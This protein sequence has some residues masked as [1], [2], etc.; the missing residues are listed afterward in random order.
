MQ[1]FE[2]GDRFDFVHGPPHWG[3][4]ALKLHDRAIVFLRSLSGR[5]YESAWR[6]HLL[7]EDIDGVPYA[8]YQHKELWLSPTLPQSLRC[9]A[10]QDPKRGQSSAIRLTEL[11]A[12]LRKLIDAEPQP[13]LPLAA[14]TG[15][16]AGTTGAVAS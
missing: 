12:Y 16:G 1:G 4:L 8:V 11:E 7:L 9:A 14:G 6:G 13:G 5:L 3:A 10:V 15:A 2:P